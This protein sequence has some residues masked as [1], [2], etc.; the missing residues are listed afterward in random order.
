MY[1]LLHIYALCI[2]VLFIKMFAISC[3][4][5]YFRIKN[6]AFKN[7]EDAQYL[8]INAHIEELPQVIR[9][10]QAWANDLENIPMFWVLGGICIALSLNS[11]LITWT[12]CIFTIA[13][14]IHTYTYL[15]RI[16]PWRTISYITGIVC[17]FILA[18]NIIVTCL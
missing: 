18:F 3:Y 13:R 16:Q 10:N 14:I 1:N 9:A 4:Q 11:P 8:N 17:L 2:T 15:V 6:K 5:G 12:F 7:K